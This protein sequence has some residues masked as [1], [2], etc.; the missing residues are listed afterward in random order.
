MRVLPGAAFAVI[1]VAAM[2]GCRREEPASPAPP[3]QTTPAPEPKG[4]AAVAPGAPGAPVVDDATITE[5]VRAAL[6]KAPDISPADIS[7]NTLNGVVQ[8]SGFVAEENQ[9]ERAGQLARS[10]DGV[11]SVENN[12]G[13]RP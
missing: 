3:A 2:G 1:L 11:R 10:V 8:L 13:V 6:S 9:V 5:R 12:L 7:V 4:P